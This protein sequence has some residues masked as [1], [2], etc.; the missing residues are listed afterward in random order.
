MSVTVK[1]GACP[2]REPGPRHG[3][4]W[5]TSEFWRNRLRSVT[6]HAIPGITRTGIYVNPSAALSV[7]TFGV[8]R[9]ARHLATVR[10]SGMKIAP[11]GARRVV[12]KAPYYCLV[13]RVGLKGKPFRIV[14]DEPITA[15]ETGELYLLTN[16]KDRATASGFWRIEIRPSE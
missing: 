13:G 10:A 15:K 11:I 3:H 8:I 2:Y 5:T 7:R 14:E 6:V 4:G 12:K 1:N 9:P 16:T